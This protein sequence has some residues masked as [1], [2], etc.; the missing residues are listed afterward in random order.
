MNGSLKDLEGLGNPE[1]LAATHELVRRGCA[2]E[3]DL[4]RHLGEVAARRLYP[5]E[6]CSSMFVYC[7]RVLQFAASAA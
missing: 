3:A 1:L 7:V 2:V 4:L 6:A 5:E